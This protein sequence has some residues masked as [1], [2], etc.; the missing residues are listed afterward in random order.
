[1]SD[2]G[3]TTSNG[4]NTGR[5]VEIKGVVIDAVFTERL[6][7]IYTA[8]AIDVRRARTA[9]RATLIAEVQQ[10]LGDD[11][12]RAVAMDSTDG[13]SRGAVCVD[14]EAPISVPVGDAD[15]RAALERH[16]RSD[17]R[18]GPGARGRRALADPPRSSGVPRSL[19]EDRDLRDWDQGHRPD[20]AV[21]EGRQGR[22]LRRRRHRQDRP[23]PG[24]HPQRRAAARRRLRVRR[25]RRADARGK[26]P[27]ARDDRVRASS[28]RSRS[29]TAR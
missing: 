14:T 13:L 29:S 4:A 1:M 25:R 5:I 7:E 9:R 27:L 12:V 23:D 11:R 10:H 15:A 20:R 18:A 24:A 8:L 3:T 19:A 22:V 28:T 16:R 17:R 21:R 2:D 26:R 6:P